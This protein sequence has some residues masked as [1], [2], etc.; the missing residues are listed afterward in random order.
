MANRREK[1]RR[2]A[3][4]L[5]REGAS[6]GSVKEEAGGKVS[7]TSPGAVPAMSRRECAEEAYPAKVVS[8]RPRTPGILTAKSDPDSGALLS[9][10]SVRRTRAL[11]T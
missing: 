11:V 6:G 7:T 2:G 3:P 1:A 4:R 8:G 5:R 10:S 9:M